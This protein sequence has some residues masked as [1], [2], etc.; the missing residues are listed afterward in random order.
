MAALNVTL[1]PAG[2]GLTDMAAAAVSAAG[3]GDTA[4]VGTGRYLVIINGDAA[5]H[6]ATLATPG[7]V[8]NLDI[9][10]AAITVAAGKTA[11]VPLTKVFAGANGRATI[12]YDGVTSVKVGVFELGT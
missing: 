4:P 12:T 7:K 10:N 2:T 9:A 5:P 1:V 8:S 6:T 11:M 3:G